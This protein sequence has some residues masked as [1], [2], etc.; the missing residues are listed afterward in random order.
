ME[1]N[2]C[3]LSIVF[4]LHMCDPY[5]HTHIIGTQYYI[6]SNLNNTRKCF[7]LVGCLTLWVD[8]VFLSD[9]KND[10]STLSNQRLAAPTL[11]LISSWSPVEEPCTTPS[12]EHNLFPLCSSFHCDFCSQ[13][14][15][16]RRFKSWKQGSKDTQIC[17]KHNQSLIQSLPPFKLSFVHH[18]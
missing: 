10:I 14:T 3:L 6:K 11:W 4:W 12:P 1:G 15:F 13:L 8:L 17:H 9:W 18:Y 16:R 2:K 5:A 7:G